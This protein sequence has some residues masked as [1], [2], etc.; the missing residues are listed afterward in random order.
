MLKI[1]AV[2]AGGGLGALLRWLLALR[3]NPA[4]G[5]PAFPAGTLAANLAGGF[6]IGLLLAAFAART[7]WPEEMRLLL[8][9]GFLGGLTTFS[10]FSGEIVQFLA[11]GRLGLGLLTLTASLG[12]SLTLTAV[13]LALGRLIFKV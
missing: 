5:G 12:G 10:T 13:G 11:Q 6:L 2:F 9:T 7:D 3:L 1:L 4:G 8:I